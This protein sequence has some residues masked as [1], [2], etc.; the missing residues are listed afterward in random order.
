MYLQCCNYSIFCAV[1]HDQMEYEVDV[2][3]NVTDIK[4]VDYL[5]RLLRNGSFS[6]VLDSYINVTQIDITTG[7]NSISPVLNT[8]CAN[9]AHYCVSILVVGILFVMITNE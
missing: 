9:I 2:E 6:L 7:K 4:A 8:M 5:R 3:L 1:V